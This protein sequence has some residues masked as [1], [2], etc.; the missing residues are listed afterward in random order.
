MKPFVPI[1]VVDS[2]LYLFGGHRRTVPGGWQF[3]EQK[4]QAFELMCLVDGRQTTEI[5][6]VGT[7]DYGAGDAMII[8]PGTLHTNKNSS[9]EETMTYICFHFNIESLEL[10]SELLGNVVNAVIP[11]EEPIAQA[12]VKAAEEIVA[13]SADNELTKEQASLKIQRAFLDFLLALTENLS[14]YAQQKGTKY[15]ESEAKTSRLI[16]TLIK[17]N[18]DQKEIPLFS[19]EDICQKVGISSGYGHRTFKKVYGVTPLHYIESQKYNKAK[20]LLGSPEYSIEDISYLM[21][22][23]STSNFTK[24][25]KK[26]AGITPSRYQRQ[27]KQKRRVRTLKESGYFE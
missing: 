19:F 13:C 22:A 8:S 5:K 20:R 26:W 21:G 10:K 6:G 24:Q 12:A 7:Y 9:D 18:I 2:S 3:F 16:A 1:P 14:S 25:F 15:S 17:K 27:M 11:A 23:S 4:H